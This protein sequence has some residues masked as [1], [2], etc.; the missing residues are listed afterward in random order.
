M[1]PLDENIIDKIL[2]W[3]SWLNNRKSG[4][5][6]SGYGH[7]AILR[8]AA[9]AEDVLLSEA[10]YKF[11]HEMSQTAWRSDGEHLYASAMVVGLLAHVDEHISEM[12]FA[13]QLAADPDDNNRACMSLL[14]FQI[15]Q[16][17]PT[18][19]DFYRHM[20]GAIKLRRGKVNIKSMIEGILLWLDEFNRPPDD[21]PAMQRL[22][23]IWAN[24][25]YLALPNN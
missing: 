7:R 22:A 19:E 8:R 25:Y 23:V 18:P 9:S 2:S 3:H 4:Q 15:L 24:D 17:S 10:F 14:R 16:K 11:L 20:L 5:R 12:S 13:A 21:T 1:Q 6:L